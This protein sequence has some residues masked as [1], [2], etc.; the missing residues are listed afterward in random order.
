MRLSYLSLNLAEL[1]LNLGA[2]SLTGAD[3]LLEAVYLLVEFFELVGLILGVA[4]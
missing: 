3:D 2:L 1:S 4:V